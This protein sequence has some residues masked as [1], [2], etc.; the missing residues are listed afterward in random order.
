MSR[1]GGKRVLAE[2]REWAGQRAYKPDPVHA[3]TALSGPSGP[4]G[5]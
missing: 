4:F 5:R 1:K 2:R 3:E